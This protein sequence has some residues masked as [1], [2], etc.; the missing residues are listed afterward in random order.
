MRNNSKRNFNKFYSRD[1]QINRR[2]RCL[3]TLHYIY[4]FNQETS[5]GVACLE[6]KDLSLR[7]E[8]RDPLIFHSES[9][10]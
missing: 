2:T 5:K 6:E 1:K 8:W 7:C 9:L 10:V 3:E 4:I